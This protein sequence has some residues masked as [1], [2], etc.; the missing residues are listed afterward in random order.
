MSAA[1]SQMAY[2]AAKAGVVQ[3]SRDLSLMVGPRVW[4]VSLL[5]ARDVPTTSSLA[6]AAAAA[7]SSPASAVSCSTRLV[8]PSRAG[9]FG[10]EVLA[11]ESQ[12]R[13]T[14]SAQH[15]EIDLDAGNL[16]ALGQSNRLRL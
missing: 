7:C 8:R 14:L 10:G 15:R 11:E 13:L 6:L 3:L 2:S 9:V 5:T 16:A 12:L 4:P 1:S